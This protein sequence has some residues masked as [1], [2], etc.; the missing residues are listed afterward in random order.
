MT[1]LAPRCT[2]IPPCWGGGRDRN[3]LEMGG[4]VKGRTRRWEGGKGD[5]DQSEV[6]FSPSHTKS[7]YDLKVDDGE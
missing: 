2:S 6:K 5:L 1:T 4:R 7:C 3:G